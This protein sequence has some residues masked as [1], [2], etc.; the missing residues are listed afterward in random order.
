MSDQRTTRLGSI[1]KSRLTTL[2]LLPIF[3]AVFVSDRCANASPRP[4]LRRL[5]PPLAVMVIL[6]T[7]GVWTLLWQQH[8][9]QLS[10]EIAA[11]ISDVAGDL[12]TAMD[13]HAS[14]MAA[15]VQPIAA[16]SA[17][18]QALRDGDIDRLLA[19]WRS[20]FE[21]LHNE[22][23]ITHFYF[24]DDNRICL[25]RVHSPEKRGDRINRFTALEAERTGKTASG[26]E[27]GPLG[28]F[29]LRVV[30]PVYE[31]GATVGY[32]ELGKGIEDVLQTLHLR[33]DIQLAV[34]IRKE[35]LDR[36]LWE[37]GMRMVG[38]EPDWDRLA[39]SVVCYASQGRLPDAFASWAD[40][41]TSEHV[42]GETDKEVAF[43][44]KDWRV[45]A[46]PLQEASGKGVGDLLIL[47]DV[48]ADKAAFIRLL[49]LGG[50]AGGMMLALS[51]SFIYV[52]LRRTDQ[53][54]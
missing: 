23:H 46:M 25:L 30:K 41:F 12:S 17:V 8:L 7:A 9:H 16:N 36:Q 10:G 26:I 11:D 20:V 31:G 15:A 14:G 27:L 29:T 42:H 38:R 19:E 37:D 34:I 49:V 48:S 52:L 45:S 54:I 53:G 32:V 33:S 21:T 24:F 51:M 4:V 13:L 40:H 43:D 35:H 2:L 1:N 3:A 18:K 44:G 5:L 47:R 39:K 28:T 6:M 22:N 50:A